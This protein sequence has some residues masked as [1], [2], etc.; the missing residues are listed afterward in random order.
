MKLNKNSLLISHQ[1]HR[2]ANCD[3]LISMIEHLLDKNILMDT[4]D[5]F[6]CYYVITAF[7]NLLCQLVKCLDI[8]KY[9]YHSYIFYEVSITAKYDFKASKAVCIVYAAE[10]NM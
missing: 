1:Y 10:I 2:Y 6:V 3:I 7:G 8:K 4:K 5:K 9:S